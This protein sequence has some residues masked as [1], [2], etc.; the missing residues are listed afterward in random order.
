MVSDD[1]LSSACT[2]IVHECISCRLASGFVLAAWVYISHDRLP[3][4]FDLRRGVYV[5]RHLKRFCRNATDFVLGRIRRLPS[6]WEHDQNA[7]AVEV[8]Q[9]Q[10]PQLRRGRLGRVGPSADWDC[11]QCWDEKPPDDFKFWSRVASSAVFVWTV[12]T[13]V[14]TYLHMYAPVDPCQ[15]R[16]GTR[17]TAGARLDRSQYYS[18]IPLIL[19]VSLGW[20]AE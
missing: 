6:Q 1:G 2:W 14:C 20:K 9:A 11:G 13:H 16:G 12:H 18:H 4:R 10:C 19:V 5:S 7:L 15:P 17:G 8:S 3:V